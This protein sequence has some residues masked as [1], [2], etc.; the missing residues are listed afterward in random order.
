MDDGF[1]EEVGD[2]VEGDVAD[3]DDDD[4]ATQEIYQANRTDSLA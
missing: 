1:D 3:E 2:D 4:V